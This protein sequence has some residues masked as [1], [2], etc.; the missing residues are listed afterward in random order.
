MFFCAHSQTI[1]EADTV[2]TKTIS[3]PSCP[4]MARSVRITEEIVAQGQ[5]QI[6]AI[7][8]HCVSTA[9]IIRYK[10]LNGSYIART[11][12]VIGG[13]GF[14]TTAD[15][16]ASANVYTLGI[17]ASYYHPVNSLPML[18]PY[19][20]RWIRC[21]IKGGRMIMNNWGPAH[22]INPAIS[23]DYAGLLCGRQ[24]ITA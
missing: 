18:L 16:H 14:S 5:E 3:T 15:I 4:I 22:S 10:L 2:H 7:A 23:I 13:N 1:F 9:T 21:D 19:K 17:P 6:K 12:R 20:S 24:R 11:Y 8:V